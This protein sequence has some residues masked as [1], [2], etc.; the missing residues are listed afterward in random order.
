MADRIAGINVKIGGDTT[1]LS[2]ALSGVNKDIRSTQSQLRDVNKLLKLDPTNTELLSQKQRLLKDAIKETEE[3]LNTLK[4]ASEKANEALAKGE[5]SQE[6]YDA[7]QREI[8][9]TTRQFNS[10][11]N[12]LAETNHSAKLAEAG[13]QE[14]TQDLK[15]EDTIA[16]K[17][18]NSTSELGDAVKNAGDKLTAGAVAAGTFIASL[19]TKAIEKATE[20]IKNL[21][22]AAVETYT[23]LDE[24]TDN[25]VKAT[26][27][28]G[29]TLESLSNSM[30]KVSQNVLVDSISDLGSAIGEVNTRFGSFDD[31]LESQTQL[32]IK[33]ADITGSDTV[34][35]V[36]SVARAMSNANIDSS[37]LE[38][39]L[40]S[41]AKAGQ[42]SG[43]SVDTLTSALESNGA[44][45][46]EM[47]F[48]VDDTIAI[49][50]TC[51]KTGLDTSTAVTA[52]KKAVQNFTK[53]GVNSTTGLQ[54]LIS[55]IQNAETSTEA[56]AMATE[57][58]GSKS[59]TEM[60]D[61]IR[62]GRFEFAEYANALAESTGTVTG[63][64]DTTQSAIDKLKL[65]IQGFKSSLGE[66]A[67]S[68]IE[69]L[70]PALEKIAALGT[71][72][73]Q[74]LSNSF[75]VG[76]FS[77]LVKET[78]NIF[79]E[80]KNKI[81]STIKDIVP[82]IA[83]KFLDL[84]PEIIT[85][86]AKGK[87]QLYS[88]FTSFLNN[89]VKIISQIDWGNMIA[90]IVVSL[91]SLINS[92]LPSILNGLT[93]L[94]QNIVTQLPTIISS[95]LGAIPTIIS[96]ITLL[97]QN[98]VPQIVSAA[99]LMFN[100]IIEA[101]PNV[102]NSIFAA[103]PDIINSIADF[104]ISSVPLI[105][106][107]AIQLLMA[108]VGAIPTIVSNMGQSLPMIIS[109]IMQILETLPG[110]LKQ[111]YAK[112][113]NKLSEFFGSMLKET[114]SRIKDFVNNW[115]EGFSNLVSIVIQKC[116]DIIN[117]IIQWAAD[118]VS[119]AKKAAS[120]FVEKIVSGLKDVPEKVY[121]TISKAV[122]KVAAWGTDMKNKAVEGMG[123]VVDGVINAF[124]N[125]PD[126]LTT[127][128][129][130]LITGLWNG[131]ADKTQWIIDKIQGFT[132]TV[133]TKIK[134]FFGI[135]SPS[136]LMRDE[137]GNY[138]AE[139]IGVGFSEGMKKTILQAKK[140][141]NMLSSAV[142]NSMS[143][144]FSAILSANNAASG[145]IVNNY[146][147]DNSR[148]INQTNNSPKSL[149]HAEIYR[150]TNNALK[151]R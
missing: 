8:I 129:G 37:E 139:G 23:D 43:I 137:V 120:G 138:L 140:A 7:L 135:A 99:V 30:S 17:A 80:L 49:L 115:K 22:S 125:L 55:E 46:R 117:K 40:D 126:N 24:G 2:K 68:L 79:S 88:W 77:G 103:L 114:A 39:T 112:I 52:M 147:Y 81:L 6:Q 98:A 38:H 1:Q 44:S 57:Y 130:N 95:L 146:A 134:S 48:N 41:L 35:A 96:Q 121:S 86:F 97:L 13:T 83:S 72:I 69:T 149:S 60:T 71:E 64:Y 14:L 105:L 104:F 128:G 42:D 111:Y 26:G 110:K 132:D 131:I 27:A 62:S 51:E 36:Q 141:S 93:I 89:L 75:S 102:I 124:K 31:E 78:V 11:N 87:A 45:F 82:E 3:K 148:T 18:E 106:D 74:R 67:K 133:L 15:E 25:L 33:Y 59:A 4:T 109:T 58:F 94:V 136:K 118:M 20:T 34:S 84:F 12:E 56:M 76:G 29:E 101:V 91:V 50:A 47:G 143:G 54:N 107:A 28:S 90:T 21:G 63:T 10:F 61:A 19:A 85:V 66:I 145:S 92:S 142:Q 116:S 16:D 73:S 150:Q 151:M 9:D 70:A 5:I 113:L 123:K 100:G 108:L 53:Q 122:S 119:N 65:T 144:N 32:F 127:V